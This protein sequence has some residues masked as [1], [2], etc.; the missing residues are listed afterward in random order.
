MITMSGPAALVAAMEFSPKRTQR[1]LIRAC[2]VAGWDPSGA[3]LLRHHTN[4]VYRLGRALV[5]VKID[6][7]GGGRSPVDVVALV[8]WLERQD[9][10][11]VPL[12]AAPQP[13]EIDGCTVTFWRYLPQRREI[14]AADLAGP[15]SMLHALRTRPPQWLPER[16]FEGTFTRITQSIDASAILSPSDRMLLRAERARLAGRAGDIAFVLPPGLVHGD[17]HHRNMLWDNATAQVLLSDLESVTVGQPEWDLV[18]VEVHCRRFAHPAME[19]EK[20][21]RDYG[22]DIRDWSGYAWLRDLRELRMITTNAYKSSPGTA[23]AREVLRRIAALRTRTSVR[24]HI[25]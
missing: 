19:Y 20:F 11:V 10:P 4:A 5:V 17:A 7:P 23:C 16:H 22:F 14:V 24:W 13:L 1:I 9:V 2:R 6:R 25:L 3:R 15:L 8:R 12:A 18:T 21:C